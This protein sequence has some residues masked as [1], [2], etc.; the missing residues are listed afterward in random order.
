MTYVNR[1][2]KNVKTESFCFTHIK[3]K[4][5]HPKT[6]TEGKVRKQKVGDKGGS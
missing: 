5:Q 4:S 2:L 3:G 1:A 6:D